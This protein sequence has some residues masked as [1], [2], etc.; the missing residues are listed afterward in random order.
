M[1]K[2]FNIRTWKGLEDA[3]KYKRAAENS[4]KKVSVWI[5]GLD[6]IVVRGE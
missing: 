5:R 2:E 3:E 1:E 6:R 4:G